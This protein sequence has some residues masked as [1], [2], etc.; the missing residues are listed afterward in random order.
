MD[1]SRRC[2]GPR[3]LPSCCR[4]VDGDAGSRSARR[5]RPRACIGGAGRD[6]ERLLLTAAATVIAEAYGPVGVRRRGRRPR[7]S[8][9]RSLQLHPRPSRA[10]VAGDV[11]GL[12]V[13]GRSRFFGDVTYGGDRASRPHPSRPRRRCVEP[14]RDV[15][16]FQ[17]AAFGDGVRTCQ[18]RPERSCRVDLHGAGA[19]VAG[20][21]DG[22]GPHRRVADRSAAPQHA[23]MWFG[24]PRA[25]RCGSGSPARRQPT[26]SS[27]SFIVVATEQPF[28]PRTPASSSTVPGC[29]VDAVQGRCW[30][31]RSARSVAAVTQLVGAVLG[32][33]GVGGALGEPRAADRHVKCTWMRR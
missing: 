28:A 7:R 14:N 3:P 11:G 33:H 30:P 22:I 25:D 13:H 20:G 6:A 5:P 17:P 10:P 15:H 9:E 8:T 2:S 24:V 26:W 18:A 4:R 23:P 1:A 32:Q 31:H 16:R 27:E 29:H 19:L 12:T 21:V